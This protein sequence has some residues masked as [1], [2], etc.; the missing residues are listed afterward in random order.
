V[1]LSPVEST[2][3]RVVVFHVEIHLNGPPSKS[4]ERKPVGFRTR[5]KAGIPVGMAF[6]NEP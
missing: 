3:K 6:P 1:G 4:E 5:E 2:E